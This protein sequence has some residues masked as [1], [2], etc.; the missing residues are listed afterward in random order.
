MPEYLQDQILG[1]N[2]LPPYVRLAFLPAA[3]RMKRVDT[4]GLVPASRAPQFTSLPG[5]A[6][7][8]ECSILGHAGVQEPLAHVARFCA[9]MSD[10][11]PV[12]LA[13]PVE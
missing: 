4:Y 5:Y 3:K 8:E 2:K 12:D 13:S 9:G 7:H 1:V 10:D 11:E 6:W